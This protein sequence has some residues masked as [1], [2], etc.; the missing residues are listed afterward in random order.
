MVQPAGL[1]NTVAGWAAEVSRRAF[2]N[3]IGFAIVHSKV[4]VID[5]NGDNPVVVT[6]SHNFSA[7]A[8]SK[9]DENLVIIRET[10]RLRA[11]TL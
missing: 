7:S 2:L 9:N 1:D 6:G 5:P 3:K 10:Q 8:S 4:V 11:P